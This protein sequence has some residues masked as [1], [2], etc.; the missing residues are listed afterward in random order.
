MEK[1]S[2]DKYGLAH[3]LRTHSVKSKWQRPLKIK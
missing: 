3:S 2:A 1:N